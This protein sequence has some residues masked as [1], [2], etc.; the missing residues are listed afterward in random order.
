MR[1]RYNIQRKKSTNKIEEVRVGKLLQEKPYLESTK[2][3]T[4]PHYDHFLTHTHIHIHN[5]LSFDL[6]YTHHII[7]S[8]L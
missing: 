7:I 2:Q 1:S 3:I 8:G 5:S 4:G 6:Y